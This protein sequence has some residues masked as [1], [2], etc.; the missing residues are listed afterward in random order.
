MSLGVSLDTAGPV[1]MTAARIYEKMPTLACSFT[2]LS[3]SSSLTTLAELRGPFPIAKSL[4]SRNLVSLGK[5][6][7]TTQLGGHL[8]AARDLIKPPNVHRQLL[9]SQRA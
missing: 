1:K 4:V 6:A 9:G 3:H 7:N 2:T 8:G 5:L